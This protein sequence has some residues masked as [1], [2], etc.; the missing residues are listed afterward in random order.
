[1]TKVEKHRSKLKNWGEQQMI[2]P[3]KDKNDTFPAF[4]KTTVFLHL[5]ILYV[6]NFI[7]KI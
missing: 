1:M 3:P 2:K 6:V 7:Q 5:Y 4:F